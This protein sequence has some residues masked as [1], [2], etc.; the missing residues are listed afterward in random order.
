MEYKTLGCR[1]YFKFFLQFFALLLMMARDIIEFVATA[2]ERLKFQ[3]VADFL[4]NNNL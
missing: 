3:T 1:L 2:N 4:E